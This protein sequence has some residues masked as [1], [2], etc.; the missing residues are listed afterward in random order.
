MIYVKLGILTTG[1]EAFSSPGREC[2]R[3]ESHSAFNQERTNHKKTKMS[4][5]SPAILEKVL[6][7]EPS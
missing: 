6:G 7:L 3:P 5:L 1:V 4:S 2:I